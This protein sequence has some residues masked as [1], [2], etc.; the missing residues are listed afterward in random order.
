MPIDSYT[1]LSWNSAYEILPTF[2]DYVPD[3]GAALTEQKVYGG[4]N[5]DAEKVRWGHTY[6][7]ILFNLP[8][9]SEKTAVITKNVPPDICTCSI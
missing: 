5:I 1:R 6:Q 3:V 8:W 7:I 2:N 9:E 4:I